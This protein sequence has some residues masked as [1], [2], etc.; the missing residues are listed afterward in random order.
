MAE[1]HLISQL[2]QVRADCLGE[3]EDVRRAIADLERQ[4]ATVLQNL[5]HVD[6]V[7][8]F[9][10]PDLALDG[11]RPRRR[12]DARTDNDDDGSD[13]K[14]QP[15]THAVLRTLRIGKRPM[16]AR[17]VMEALRTEYSDGDE[18]KLLRSISTFLSVK[19]KEGLLQGVA[20]DGD[21]T[22]YMV[23]A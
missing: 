2:K 22:R 20:N 21:V 13:T 14:R 23:A 17:E 11:I 15:M 1:S 19:K 6:G 16:S 8:R 12:R 4:E 10:A 5:Q 3:L 7:L 18:G 9:K